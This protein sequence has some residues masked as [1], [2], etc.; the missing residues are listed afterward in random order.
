[1]QSISDYMAERHRVC[2]ELF[3]VA[4][5]AAGNGDWDAAAKQFTEFHRAMEEHFTEEEGTLFPAFEEA[6]GMTMGPTYVM[7]SEH[8]NMRDMFD[9][10]KQAVEAKDAD[11]YLGLAETALVLIQQHNLKE[12][13]ILYPMM[14]QTMAD[15]SERLIAQ[16]D[17]NRAP[18]A[19][20]CQCAGR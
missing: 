12:D 7:K 1:M 8:G 10:M 2:D 9:E 20:A 19:A 16:L 14:D 15:S 3:A 6:T 13:Q 5:E 11:S 17:L 4:E 18:R